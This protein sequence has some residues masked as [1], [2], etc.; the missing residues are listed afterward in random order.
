MKLKNLLNILFSKDSILI[1]KLMIWNKSCFE[2]FLHS[3]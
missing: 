1:L 2:D 3:F